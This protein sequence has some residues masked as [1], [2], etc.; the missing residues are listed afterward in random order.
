MASL[1][2]CDHNSLKTTNYWQVF[3]PPDIVQSH[4]Y[5]DSNTTST[6]CMQHNRQLI[7]W[8]QIPQLYFFEKQWQWWLHLMKHST[9]YGISI[10]SHELN[11]VHSTDNNFSP[12]SENNFYSG[13]WNIS[14]HLWQHSLSEPLSHG[15][16]DHTIKLLPGS[17]HSLS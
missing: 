4:N 10:S 17:N 3:L 16:S 8:H 15:P 11:L 2:R 7:S 14:Y 12:D 9:S 5:Q 6:T 13:C 1:V